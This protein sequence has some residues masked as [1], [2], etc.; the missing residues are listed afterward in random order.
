MS[1]SREEI[2]AASK[3]NAELLK[4]SFVSSRFS[5]V[6]DSAPEPAPEPETAPEPA[7]KQEVVQGEV[8]T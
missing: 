8:G 1:L 6:V 5:T 2:I 4:K 7:P 3:E